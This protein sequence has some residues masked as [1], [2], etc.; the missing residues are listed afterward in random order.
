MDGEWQ[1]HQFK[2][3]R[4]HSPPFSIWYPHCVVPVR[5]GHH[6]DQ[7]LTGIF[8]FVIHRPVDIIHLDLFEI[9]VQG[10]FNP[11]REVFS[12]PQAP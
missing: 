8:S 2:I 4:Q 7:S 3:E 1:F 10:M 9:V 11:P 12:R 6:T 5:L